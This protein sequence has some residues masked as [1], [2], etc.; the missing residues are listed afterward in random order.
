[1]STVSVVIPTF[2]GGPLFHEVLEKLRTQRFA[3]PIELLIID[4]GSNDQTLQAA[5]QAG[6][7]VLQIPSHDFDHGLTRNRGIDASAGDLIIL[8]TQDAVPADNHLIAR[9]AAAFDD[10]RVGGAFAR[11]LPRPEHDVLVA[12]NIR[13]WIAGSPTPRVSDITDR[14][15]YDHLSPLDKF[16]FCVFDN[17]CSAVRREAWRNIPFHQNAFGEDIEWSRRALEAGWK[18]AY[19]PQAAVI[20]SHDRSALY[21]YKRT[22][23]C[24]Q[25]L[26]R[27]F[28]VRTIPTAGRVPGCLWRSITSDMAYV[29]RHEKRLA[30]KLSL[31]AKIPGLSFGSVLGQYCGARDQHRGAA[32][33]F[34][35]V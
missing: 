4:S 15:H 9:L 7:K 19:Q 25:T 3:N 13:S 2:N 34:K 29:L 33:R 24:H 22:Y 16:M 30:Q 23:M 20:H 12:R 32:K 17:V 14:T 10:P 11:Q 31:L 18:I 35:G 5:Q 27:L 28:N 26:R 6:A 21:E 8:M 1:M